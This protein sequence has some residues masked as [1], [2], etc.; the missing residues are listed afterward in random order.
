MNADEPN[1]ARIGDCPLQTATAYFAS[2]SACAL[3]AVDRGAPSCRKRRGRENDV[4]LKVG[5]S[6]VFSRS[7][8]AIGKTYEPNLREDWSVRREERENG[9]KRPTWYFDI[10]SSSPGAK[11]ILAAHPTSLTIL[12]FL[13]P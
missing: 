5:N 4:S 11:V 1:E 2:S 12:P 3:R 13:S 6:C 10:F 7:R 9:G 8:K